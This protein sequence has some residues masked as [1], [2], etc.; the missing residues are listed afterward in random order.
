MGLATLLCRLRAAPWQPA[1]SVNEI[2]R[3]PLIRR[4]T[5]AARVLLLAN[6]SGSIVHE[7]GEIMHTR[8]YSRNTREISRHEPW[9]RKPLASGERNM[10]NRVSSSRY[11]CMDLHDR[12]V[13]MKKHTGR[14]AS[15]LGEGSPVALRLTLPTIYHTWK[16]SK[17]LCPWTERG[18]SDGRKFSNW[19]I[20]Y[21]S[22]N[23]TGFKTIPGRTNDLCKRSSRR[24][25]PRRCFSSKGTS[26]NKSTK[27]GECHD[28]MTSAGGREGEAA[29]DCS[30]VNCDTSSRLS[31]AEFYPECSAP[32]E[33]SVKDPCC[34]PRPPPSCPS[35]AFAS[36]CPNVEDYCPK[37]GSPHERFWRTL[38]VFVMMPV[39]LVTTAFVY[40]T[41][42]E[43]KNEPRPE[44][45]DYLFMRRIIKPF[46][47]GDGRR[48]LFH[49]PVKNPIAPHGY[50]VP[51]PNAAKTSQRKD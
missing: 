33:P 40:S 25:D 15:F 5:E 49:N 34:K 47:W 1:A 32:C 10:S 9:R 43:S 27:P 6:K 16:F 8:R 35:S 11:A 21:S 14:R 46:P 18:V 44:F 37:E 51:D 50:E 39:L 12:C 36:P 28:Q 17:E 41:K 19:S 26:C 7:D 29:K 20:V 31:A 30:A 24:R 3:S 13:E 38:S 48:T 23:D 42:M 2:L 4:N 22:M 45:I